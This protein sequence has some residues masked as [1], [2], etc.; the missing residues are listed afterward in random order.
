[1]II[2]ASLEMSMLAGQVYEVL[3]CWSSHRILTPRNGRN[4]DVCAFYSATLPI[5]FWSASRGSCEQPHQIMFCA[6]VKI[7]HFTW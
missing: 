7:K 5:A 4:S 6:R 1:M 2:E 3:W